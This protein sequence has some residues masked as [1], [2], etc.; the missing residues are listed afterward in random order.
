MDKRKCLCYNSDMNG[1]F[2]MLAFVIGWFVAQLW[3]TVA[4]ILKGDFRGRSFLEFLAYATRSGGMPSGHSA[5][6]MAMTIYIGMT[7]GFGTELFALALAVSLI[8]I[9]DATHVR[10]AVGE[11]G[12][13]L[14]EMLVKDDQKPLKIV[15]GHTMVQVAVGILIG[16]VTGV[17]MGILLKA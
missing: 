11:Q 4:G 14:N 1:W 5:S 13:V 8:V 12:K 3:K 6:M 16:V 7:A 17:V 9:Y 15:E 2:A 10:Y